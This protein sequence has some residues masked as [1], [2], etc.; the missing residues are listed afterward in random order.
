MNLKEAMIKLIEDKPLGEKYAGNARE[1]K[2]IDKKKNILLVI[3][4]NYNLGYSFSTLRYIHDQKTHVKIN[5]KYYKK[6]FYQYIY[7]FIIINL[8]IEFAC[9]IKNLNLENNSYV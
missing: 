9:L 2:L 7:K 6:L 4:Y 5:A 1:M 8:K 3:L